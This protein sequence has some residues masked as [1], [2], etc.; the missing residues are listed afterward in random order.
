MQL[1]CSGRGGGGWWEE[2]ERVSNT[3]EVAVWHVSPKLALHLTKAGFTSS[4]KYEIP[5]GLGTECGETL[6]TKALISFSFISGAHTH[7]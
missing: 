7:S 1:R 2:V 3:M 4:V 6:R 5:A